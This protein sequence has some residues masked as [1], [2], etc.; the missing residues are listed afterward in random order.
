MDLERRSYET[1]RLMEVVWS[2]CT[3][4]QREK[5]K[6]DEFQKMYEN[7]EPDEKP[8]ERELKEQFKQTFYS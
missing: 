6:G 1:E 4:E 5:L 2:V 8:T 3:E 7:A